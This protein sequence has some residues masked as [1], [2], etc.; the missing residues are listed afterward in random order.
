MSKLTIVATME[1]KPGTR[2]EVLAAMK[3][4]R[5]RCLRDEPGTLQ[6]DVLV[7][8]K[9]DDKIMIY[10]VYRDA[11]AFKLHWDGA[12]MKTVRTEIGDRMVKMTGVR[13]ASA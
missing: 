4:H 1:L 11:E 12:S 6:F 7:P 3:A 2:S 8:E 5:E 9:E 13:C 10:E